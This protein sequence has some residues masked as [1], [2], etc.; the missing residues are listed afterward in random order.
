M[1]AKSSP[2]DSIPTSVIKTCAETFALLI[3]RLVTLSFAEGEFP[4]KYKYTRLSLHFS[5][6]KAWTAT[7][8]AAIDRSPIFTRYRWLWNVCSCRSLSTISDVIFKNLPGLGLGLVLR[9]TIMTPV[10]RKYQNLRPTNSCQVLWRLYS[11][12]F[13]KRVKSSVHVS[14]LS[15]SVCTAIVHRR[16]GYYSKHI[17]QSH[18]CSRKHNAMNAFY[19]L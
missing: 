12:A 19:N 18:V 13:V 14:V 8:S 10:N 6:K 2:L 9:T 11:W 1:P 5:R 3:A 17:F 16:R 4:E 7:R 15:V